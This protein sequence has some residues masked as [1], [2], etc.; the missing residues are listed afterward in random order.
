[1]AA[2]VTTWPRLLAT[3]CLSCALCLGATSGASAAD[4]TSAG[5]VAADPTDTARYFVEDWK[6]M[7]DDLF[8]VYSKAWRVDGLAD[9]TP[10]LLPHLSSFVV[11]DHVS[12]AAF[13]GA[14][15]LIVCANGEFI[16]LDPTGSTIDT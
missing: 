6:P 2:S 11:R 5:A 14:G 4:T 13:D 9:A 16:R 15:R 7:P 3:A 12:D 10:T 1:M 8:L